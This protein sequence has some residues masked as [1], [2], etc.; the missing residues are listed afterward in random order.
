[1]EE[2]LKTV[3]S[4]MGF[5]LVWWVCKSLFDGNSSFLIVARWVTWFVVGS[6]LYIINLIIFNSDAGK[7]IKS[8]IKR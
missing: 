4:S 8:L 6:L 2:M 5:V 7:R 1:M 3:V